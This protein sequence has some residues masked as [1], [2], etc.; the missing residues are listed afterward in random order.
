MIDLTDKV[1][2]VT[3]GASGIGKGIGR[4]LAGQGA[5][6]TVADLN[7]AGA[8]AE[9]EELASAGRTALAA[10]VDVT[11]RGSV[12]SMVEDVL[13][14]FGRIDCLI[15][16]AGV[17]GA[18]GW[19]ER[20]EPSDADWDLVMAVNLR[21]VVN[22][23][24]AVAQ[25]MKQRRE[26][27]IINIASIA[28]RQGGAMNPPYNASKTAVISWTQSHAMTLAPF[29]VNVNAICPGSLWTPLY[30]RLMKRNSN[31]SGSATSDESDR[32]TFVNQAESRIPLKREQTP[33][34][35]G[36][37]AA[38]LVSADAWNITGQ[39]I[40]LDGGSRLN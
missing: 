29:N 17:V 9:A 5:L 36:N 24:E 11:D 40:N 6:V 33:E 2:I 25:S 3:G 16:N 14:E 4:V 31:L 26:G 23:S 15:N 34:D 10:G 21:G 1:A 32:E 37:L 8:K 38:F 28:G 12:Q 39:S 18:P 30:E 19:E 7:E 13:R 27:K 35:V 22:V 20:Q